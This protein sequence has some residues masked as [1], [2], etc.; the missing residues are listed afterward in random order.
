[1]SLYFLFYF[2]IL[3]NPDSYRSSCETQIVLKENTK[4]NKQFL[5]N[6][7]TLLIVFLEG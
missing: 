4:N 1:M 2:T 6:K 3:K 7:K 5:V